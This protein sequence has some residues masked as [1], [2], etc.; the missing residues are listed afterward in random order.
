MKRLY[1]EKKCRVSA[2]QKKN[3]NVNRPTPNLTTYKFRDK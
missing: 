3:H 2:M 1:E